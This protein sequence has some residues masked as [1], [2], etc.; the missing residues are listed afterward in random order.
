MSTVCKLG[1]VRNNKV[2]GIFCYK[3][4]PMSMKKGDITEGQEEEEEIL[5]FLWFYFVARTIKNQ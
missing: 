3:L 5:K 4:L 1:V 2:S